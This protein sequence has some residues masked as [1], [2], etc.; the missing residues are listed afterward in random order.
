MI[1]AAAVWHNLRIGSRHRALVVSTVTSVVGEFRLIS[2]VARYVDLPVWR[3]AM[4]T[5]IYLKPAVL[6]LLKGTATF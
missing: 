1:Q 6:R 5:Q 2:G 4:L 3:E